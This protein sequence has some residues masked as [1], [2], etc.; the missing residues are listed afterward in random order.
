MRGEA[1]LG[2]LEHNAVGQGL[3]L[4][5]ELVV[6]SLLP[7]ALREPRAYGLQ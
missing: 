7:P 6:E 5:E 2:M 4:R 1:A 3:G